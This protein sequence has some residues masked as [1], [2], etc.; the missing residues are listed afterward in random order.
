VSRY[1]ASLIHLCVSA[2][3]V[4]SFF[5]LVYYFWYPAPYFLFSDVTDPMIMIAGVDIVLGPIL[6]LAVFKSGKKGMLFDLCCIG[7]LQFSA[8]T[9]GGYAIFQGRP[10]YIVYGD[11]KFNYLT[12]AQV[13]R[14]LLT[15]TDLQSYS[16][17]PIMAY[18]PPPKDEI[19]KNILA[20]LGPEAAFEYYV[21]FFPNLKDVLLGSLTVEKLAHIDPRNKIAL[22]NFV[23]SHDK[24]I[25][26]Y[27]Y[28]QLFKGKKSIVVA[29]ERATGEIVGSI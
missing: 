20:F 17:K 7:A 6:T 2:T 21:P 22:D 15:N 23:K 13:D 14:T 9:Y 5:M 4:L 28:Y 18:N 3:A 11:G 12:E 10:A 8:L 16:M 27:A 26:D 19:T 1:K 29:L 25:N 24:E